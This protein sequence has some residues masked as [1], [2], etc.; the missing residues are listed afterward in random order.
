VSNSSVVALNRIVAFRRVN[1]AKAAMEELS[2]LE[3][4]EG[5]TNYYLFHAIKA[6]LLIDESQ[7][8]EAVVSLKKA[9]ALTKNKTEKIH[10][11]K[12]LEYLKIV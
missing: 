11:N 9:I 6:E 12:K 2:K 4:R 8:E 7:S 3:N 5:M 1:G 10:L